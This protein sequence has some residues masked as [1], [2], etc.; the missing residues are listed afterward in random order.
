MLQPLQVLHL[1]QQPVKGDAQVPLP[2]AV[3]A[4]SN[5]CWSDD[6]DV[7][8]VVD[9]EDDAGLHARQVEKE[10][11]EGEFRGVF[12]RYIA[13]C[14]KVV[15]HKEFPDPKLGIPSEGVDPIKHLRE[16][17]L[18]KLFKQWI[19]TDVRRT[20]F[21]YLPYMATHSRASVGSLLASSYCER[22]NS[23]SKIIF[24]KSNASL[25]PDEMGML[26]TL[27]MNQEFMKYMRTHFPLEAKQT[28]GMTL[29]PEERR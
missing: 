23:A 9:E 6:D 17:P 13:A 25:S 29:V 20:K 3:S 19:A 4:F 1:L 21:G 8:E 5:S 24:N 27:R 22:V 12:S 10:R 7:E 14:K 28:Y 18:G 26:S 11:L 2:Q 15:W 16:V